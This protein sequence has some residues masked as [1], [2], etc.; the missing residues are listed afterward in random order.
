M[1]I[2]FSFQTRRGCEAV[3]Q[4]GRGVEEVADHCRDPREE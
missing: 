3:H 4:E 2:L 1:L